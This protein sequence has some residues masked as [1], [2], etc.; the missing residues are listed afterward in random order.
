MLLRKLPYLEL[1]GA[2]PDLAVAPAT[3]GMLVIQW[4]PW[5]IVVPEQLAVR[6]DQ[7]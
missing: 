1:V 7:R 5:L 3:G 6:G 4:Y 2:I